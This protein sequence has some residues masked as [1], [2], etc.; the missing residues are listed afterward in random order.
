[1]AGGHLRNLM[2]L[3]R[4]ACTASGKLPLTS[5]AIERSVRDMS[6]AFE[7]AL[8]KP[9]FFKVLREI[10]KK[11]ELPGSDYDQELLYNLSLLEYLNG[12]VWYAVNPAVRLLEKFQGP[13]RVP[14]KSKR[15]SSA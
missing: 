7:R 12:E 14:G 10:D 3:I 2:I 4:G 1:M 8:N 11:H 6:N 9:D 5:Q 15:N 13:K